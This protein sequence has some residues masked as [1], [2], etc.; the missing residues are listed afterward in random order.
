[1]I[2]FQVLCLLLILVL[3][4]FLVEEFFNLIFKGY[5]PLVSSRSKVLDE[6]VQQFISLDLPAGAKVYELGCGQAGFLRH[7]E[8]TI[9]DKEKYKL[10]GI[11]L[12]FSVFLLAKLQLFLV[13]SK[14]KIIRKNFLKMSL[15]DVDCFYCYLNGPMM[16]RLSLKLKK[17]AKPG[18]ILISNQFELP[19]YE[20]IE[21]IRLGLTNCLRIY[22]L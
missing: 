9:E 6:A 2:W 15:K 12:L 18:A 16:A 5:A 10:V 13:G 1:M 4:T 11:E 20:P 7:L 19:G 21:E 8:K 14:I 22:K 17:E 3:L